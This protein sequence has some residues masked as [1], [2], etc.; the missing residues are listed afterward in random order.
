MAISGDPRRRSVALLAGGVVLFFALLGALQWFNTSSVRF[1]NPETSGETLVFTS[2]TVLV[3]LL[4]LTLLM[5]LLRNIL[6]LYVG[7]T[8]S[9]LGAR[10]RTRMVLGAA[11][12][13]LTPAVFMFLFSF[14]L[15]NRSIDRW[16]SQPTSELREDSTR[17]VLELAQYVTENARVE[18]ESIAA[19][20]TPDKNPA[21]LKDILGSHRITLGG[22]FAVVYGK[23]FHPIAN[24]Q[25]PA[26][27]SQASLLP[28]LPEKNDAGNLGAAVPLRQPEPSLEKLI[29]SLGSAGPGPAGAPAEANDRRSTCSPR[30]CRRWTTR[31]W[32]ACATRYTRATWSSRKW[33]MPRRETRKR[34]LSTWSIPRAA[35]SRAWWPM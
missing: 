8:S 26:E 15:M 12:I 2:L 22:G 30:P 1:L 28:W 21:E 29:Y 24:F 11:L 34:K 16:F 20:A 33:T 31:W 5:L 6:K 14:N 23:D 17:V 13:A 3:F 7:Q 19:S 4:L 9:A 18:A 35:P 32:A 25:S 27:T 10:L